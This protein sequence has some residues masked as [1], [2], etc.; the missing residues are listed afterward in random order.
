MALIFSSNTESVDDIKIVSYHWEEIEGP[1][2][3]K[4]A[5]AD[6]PLLYLS[7][8]IPGNYTFRW[9]ILIIAFTTKYKLS[10]GIPTS[11]FR[12]IPQIVYI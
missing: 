1:L 4:K 5:S 3:E 8:L 12:E 2:R 7:N 6:T 10:Q 11:A 9:V